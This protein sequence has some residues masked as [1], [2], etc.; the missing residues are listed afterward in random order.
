MRLAPNSAT[1]LKI[2]T[3]LFFRA[4]IL[5]ASRHVPRSGIQR[6]LSN[7]PP[8][9][10]FGSLSIPVL[11]PKDLIKLGVDRLTLSAFLSRWQWHVYLYPN[12]NASLRVPSMVG[13][14]SSAVSRQY[15]HLTTDDQR[16]AMQRLPD[17]TDT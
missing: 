3:M 13:H 7:R 10:G 8:F 12:I 6:S 9:D 1:L 2:P 15:T 17:V 14:E 4:L 16:A 5:S 11:K